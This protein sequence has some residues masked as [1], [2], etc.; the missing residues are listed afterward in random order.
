MNADGLSTFRTEEAQPVLEL[1]DRRDHLPPTCV[2]WP[3]SI[4]I[5]A[6]GSQTSVH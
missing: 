2:H 4:G 3:L 6:N 1:G 5:K